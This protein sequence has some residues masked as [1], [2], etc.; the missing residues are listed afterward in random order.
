M[1]GLECFAKRLGSSVSFVSSHAYSPSFAPIN[2][3]QPYLLPR[4]F[5]KALLHKTLEML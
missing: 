1:K 2:S 4:P 3:S 5:A